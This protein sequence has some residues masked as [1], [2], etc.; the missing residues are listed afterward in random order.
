MRRCHVTT[1]K[2][3]VI[4]FD[5]ATNTL[6]L[7][8]DHL[9]VRCESDKVISVHTDNPEFTKSD[10]PELISLLNLVYDNTYS[11]GKTG[12]SIHLPLKRCDN[13]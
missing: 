1:T 13:A 9:S 8:I 4:Q 5:T 12:W 10:I 6:T 2:T 3:A 11:N 7:S